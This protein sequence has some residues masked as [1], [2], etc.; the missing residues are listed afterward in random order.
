VVNRLNN[1]QIFVILL[2][3][4]SLC[5]ADHAIDG[6]AKNVP[7]DSKA[8]VNAQSKRQNVLLTEQLSG[9]WELPAVKDGTYFRKATVDIRNQ[10]IEVTVALYSDEACTKPYRIG[11]YRGDIQQK[12]MGNGNFDLGIIW[13]NFEW[14]ILG[15]TVKGDWD[16]SIK[17]SEPRLGSF[18]L[19]KSGQSPQEM[20]A[21]LFTERGN[22]LTIE[23]EKRN[24]DRDTAFQEIEHLELERK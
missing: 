22:I 10:T 6:G 3:L 2:F 21:K 20:V 1:R 11:R 12:P 19:R 24:A 8:P 18:L 17:D 4:S 15:N 9:V 23:F 16:F 5:S 13:K 7:P 14:N